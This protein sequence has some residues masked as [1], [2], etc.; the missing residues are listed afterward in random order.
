[1]NKPRSNRIST[2]RR[3]AGMSQQQLADAIKVHWTTISKLERGVTKLDFEYAEIIAN[4]LGVD[5]SQVLPEFKPSV[6]I[7]VSGYVHFGG[8]VEAIDESKPDAFYIDSSVFYSEGT[9][10]IVVQKNA[11]YPYFRHGDLIGVTWISDLERQ[12]KD[13]NIDYSK[14][15]GRFCLVEDESEHQFMGVL[16]SGDSRETVDLLNANFPPLK[17][18]RPRSLGQVTVAVMP[19]PATEH[20][21]RDR[22]DS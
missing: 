6:L 22:G 16:S 13:G 5:T 18:I 1:M 9:I 2:V 8:E 7:A 10:W 17:N 21:V 12:D 4:A 11:L 19:T 15:I 3:A 14:F 20:W